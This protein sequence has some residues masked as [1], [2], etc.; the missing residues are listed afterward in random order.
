MRGAA[1][2]EIL[3]SSALSSMSP[4]SSPCSSS[5]PPSQLGFMGI[6]Y[7]LFAFNVAHS[8]EASAE[9]SALLAA[10]TH[11]AVGDRSQDFHIYTDSL[12][13]IYMIRRTLDAPWTLKESKHFDLLAQI[14]VAL[15]A[16]ATADGH[17]FIYKVKAHSGSEGN[18]RADSGAKAAANHPDR[19]DR[20]EESDNQ[21]N[22]TT[23]GRGPAWPQR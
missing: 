6:L 10:L 22:P 4:S 1:A 19:A 16:R 23:T 15:R 21:F 13:S 2:V 18:D 9:L 8:V 14:Q 20:V 11:P 5:L 12:C 17:T 3:P 7:A